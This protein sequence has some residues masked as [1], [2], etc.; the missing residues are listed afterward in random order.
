MSSSMDSGYYVSEAEKAR[1][2]KCSKAWNKKHKW[3][4]KGGWPS[5]WHECK[6]CKALIYSK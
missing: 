3:I 1:K 5:I 4:E 2:T 6:Y